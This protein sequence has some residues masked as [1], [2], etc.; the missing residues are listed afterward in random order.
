MMPFT[1]PSVVSCSPSI[2]APEIGND[3]KVLAGVVALV[4]LGS[5]ALQQSLAQGIVQYR[6]M[7]FESVCF[8]TNALATVCQYT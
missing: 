8:G 7:V 5:M 2:L 4:V 1:S 3:N 6:F